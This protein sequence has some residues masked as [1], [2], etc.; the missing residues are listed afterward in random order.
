[1]H[2][3]THMTLTGL[4]HMPQMVRRQAVTCRRC[5]GRAAAMIVCGEPVGLD[6]RD[7]QIAARTPIR[8][9]RCVTPERARKSLDRHPNY[10]LAAYMACGTRPE[11]SGLGDTRHCR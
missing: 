10:I 1:V 3:R 11:R 2:E 6:L 8:G 7:V 9:P 4:T 5:S